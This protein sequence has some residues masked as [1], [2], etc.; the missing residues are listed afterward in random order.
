MIYLFVVMLFKQKNFQKILWHSINKNYEFLMRNSYFQLINCFGK[1]I[2][3]YLNT[4]QI[5]NSN[6]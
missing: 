4:K 3:F 1:K 6:T 2:L 5:N